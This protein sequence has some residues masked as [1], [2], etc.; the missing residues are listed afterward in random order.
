M[1]RFRDAC[2]WARPRIGVS[3]QRSWSSDH[4]CTERESQRT[5]IE[6]WSLQPN[7]PLC[8]CAD[9]SLSQPAAGTPCHSSP[10]GAGKVMKIPSSRSLSLT[11]SVASRCLKVS[12]P[13]FDEDTGHPRNLHDTC[14]PCWT[15]TTRRASPES[16]SGRPSTRRMI[17]QCASTSTKHDSH[18]HTSGNKI[19]RPPARKPLV[20]RKDKIASHKLQPSYHQPTQKNI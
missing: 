2:T 15:P 5:T 11:V 10:E 18:S 14:L 20:S 12:K 6:S 3:V 13:S 7:R 19:T 4:R 9:R 8:P 1:Q 16:S 17:S